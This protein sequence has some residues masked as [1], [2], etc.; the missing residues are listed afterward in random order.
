MPDTIRKDLFVG[1][2]KEIGIF[3]KTLTEKFGTSDVGDESAEPK[4]LVFYGVAGTCPDPHA[5]HRF[6][7]LGDGN[8]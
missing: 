8:A 3:E 2:E 6:R 5:G 4:V 1:R 7:W